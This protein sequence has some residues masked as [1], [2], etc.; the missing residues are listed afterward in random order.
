M[1]WEPR[2]RHEFFTAEVFLKQKNVGGEKTYNKTI[3]GRKWLHFVWQQLL[4]RI[5]KFYRIIKKDFFIYTNDNN[6][7][8]LIKQKWSSYIKSVEIEM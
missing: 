4:W 2:R 1:G 3:L 5:L 7:N 6:G 8:G